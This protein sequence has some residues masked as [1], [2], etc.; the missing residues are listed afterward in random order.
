MPSKKR[1]QSE[2]VPITLDRALQREIVGVLL[3]AVGAVT[4]LALL[5]ITKGA[6]SE[7]WVTFLRRIWGWGV[8]P[9]ALALI[10]GGVYLLGE[11][12]REHFTVPA[13]SVFGAELLFFS[14]LGLSHL[15]A[16]PEEAVQLADSGGGGGYVG[17]TV[18]YLLTTAVGR[19]GAV[20]ILLVV[21]C[22]GSA[23][24]TN[25]Q[26]DDVE[27][28]LVRLRARLERL[29]TPAELLASPP[30]RKRAPHPKRAAARRESE[31]G[32]ETVST[33]K[34]RRRR[35]RRLPPLDL[36]N[37]GADE[38]Y[39]DA[40]VRY[41]QQVIEETL[42]S[43]GV[44]AQVVEINVGPTITQFGVEPGFL[45]YR[46]RDGEVRRRKVKVSKIM[47]LQD[48]LALA[49][50]AAPIRIEA[51]VPGRS[52]VGIEVPNKEP[53]FVGLR[54]VVESGVFQSIRSPLRIALGRGV[55]GRPVAADLAQMPHLLIAGA[56]GTGKS[57]CLSTITACLL[58][59]NT[60]DELRLLMI[61]PKRVEMSG[62]NG[63]PHLLAPAA[64]E[65]E[66]VI[67]ALRWVAG[68]M[69]RR[70]KLFSER[71]A[72]NLDAY[73]EMMASRGKERL[74]RIVVLIDEL[75][76]LMMHAPDEIERSICRI[77]QLARATG[78]HLVIATQRPSV[79]VV[80]GLIKANFPARISFSV[81]SQTDSRVVLDSGG[82]EKLLG[83]G[84]MLY[85]ASDSSKLVRL[86]GCFVS[87]DELQ[88]LRRF[89]CDRIDWITESDVPVP[90]HG[91]ALPG[92]DTDELFVQAIELAGLQDTISTSFLQRRL[93]VGYPR[94]A[95]LM[96]MLEEQGI[97]GPAEGGG[98]SREVLIDDDVR[99]E[100][101]EDELL[102]E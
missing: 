70:Y 57:V 87:D 11:D 88:R 13:R 86:Q 1:Q 28:V 41:R 83:Q 82:A 8:Y 38:A 59:D 23:L 44:P 64:I 46:Q 22:L 84:D 81:T 5:S 19:G 37:G 47:A 51:P 97:V 98:R 10:V 32:A 6:L 68:E 34:P 39:G 48:D 42:A 3:V 85:M 9:I 36:L 65:V 90:W 52:V 27:Q 25:L 35:D 21:V 63:I 14:L 4:T 20:A 96:D 18:S 100:E 61:D 56:T 50:A 77:A 95:R 73:N 67:R 94:A 43:F 76:D 24:I 62:M 101:E 71:A 78:I 15:V 80:T 40:D 55:G 2:S 53:S 26:R 54:S 33:R 58:L 92:H 31:R 72:R 79:D 93:R 7:A 75:A 29:R 89:W 69:D 74:P 99:T 91:M 49:L 30:K 66:E 17:W 45:E 12:L 60:P 16:S 102:S